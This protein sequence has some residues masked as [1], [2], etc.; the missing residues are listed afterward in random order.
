MPRFGPQRRDRP[1]IATGETKYHGD[2]VAAVAAE[3]KDAAEE[4]AALV[5][6]AYEELPPA[7]TLETAL[8]TD[9]PLVQDPSLRPDDPHADT[10][11][12]HEHRHVWGDIDGAFRDAA[13]VFQ[14]TFRWNRLGANPLETFGVVSQWDL[15]EN[16][17]T[18]YG[19]FQSQFHMA[20]ARGA[21]FNLPPNKVRLVAQP[22][23]GSF[24]G[25]PM[26]QEIGLGKAKRVAWLEVLWPATGE[27]QQ[28][29][30]E[31]GAPNALIRHGWN[32]NSVPAGTKVH[33]EGFQA[34]DRTFRASGRD[35]TLPD[36]KSLFMGQGGAAAPS[37]E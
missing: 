7:F 11:V 22:H 32:R 15:L 35:I 33:V 17:I 31:G 25:N 30:V 9:A 36:G 4:A 5:K 21:V 34:K 16:T 24:G 26:R 28:W 19:S 27:K 10:N 1:V 18:C 13:N 8:A 2:P 23:G 3:T 14:D 29:A 12:L 6:V 20:L 37:A